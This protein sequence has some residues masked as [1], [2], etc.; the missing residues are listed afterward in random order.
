MTKGSD[1]DHVDE[2]LRQ[3]LRRAFDGALEEEVP[4]VF[5]ELIEELQTA[6]ERRSND[7]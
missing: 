6:K 3:S 1:K 2:H 5:L 7:P 4:G